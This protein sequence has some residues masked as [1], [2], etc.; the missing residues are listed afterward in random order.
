MP[1]LAFRLPRRAAAAA[2]A[3]AAGATIA[4]AATRVLA[5]A[6]SAAVHGSGVDADGAE[7]AG[8][9][10][11]TTV[12]GY[13]ADGAGPDASTA[14]DTRS[15]DGAAPVDGSRSGPLRVLVFSATAGY[16]HASIPDGI[17]AL[18]ML[19]SQRGWTIS[20]TEDATQF[21]DS[22][23]S[24]LDVIV[25]LSTTG[26][27]LDTDQ[28]AALVRYVQSGK[29]W[30]GIHSASDTEHDWPWYGGL[31]GAYFSSHPDIQQASIRV[32]DPT[33][34]ST[35][36]LPNPWVRTDEWYAFTSNPRGR[37]HVLLSLDESSYSPG[38]SGM[39]GDHPIAWDQTFEGGRSFYTALGH[40]SE[41]YQEPL[42]LAHLTGAIEWAGGM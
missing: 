18:Q 22:T 8:P 26:D 3:I 7:N 31:V 6:P 9:D 38:D 25:F 23:L 35:V 2:R 29:G 24:A 36:G 19:A 17:A 34:P 10:A 16:R 32:E 41:S 37:V 42:F 40:T 20:A 11:S 21:Q 12:N 5:C 4:V 28:Q 1:A 27:V 39:D 30:V 13:G 14:A 15:G 33:H